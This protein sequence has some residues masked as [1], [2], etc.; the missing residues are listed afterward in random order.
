MSRLE[1]LRKAVQTYSASR[2]KPGHALVVDHKTGKTS[3]SKSPKATGVVAHFKLGK[4]KGGHDITSHSHKAPSSGWGSSDHMDAYRAHAR[5]VAE[6]DPSDTHQGLIKHHKAAMAHHWDHAMQ[7]HPS[8]KKSGF[9]EEY[10]WFQKAYA[11][12]VIGRT[13]SGKKI[14]SHHSHRSHAKYDHND[15]RDAAHVHHKK[16]MRIMDKMH[17]TKGKM[18][19]ALSRLLNKHSHA[20]HGHHGKAHKKK[21]AGRH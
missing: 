11:H 12:H 1:E 5:H 13:K 16:A 21:N 19:S 2:Y 20:A 18:R 17:K 14:Y 3:Y 8:M 9:F 4:T 6:L 10:E 7:P 15:H